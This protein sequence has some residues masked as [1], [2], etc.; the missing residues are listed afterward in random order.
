MPLIPFYQPP[1]PDDDDFDDEEPEDD[2]EEG[3]VNLPVG[4]YV[5]GDVAF[6]VN[7]EGFTFGDIDQIRRAHLTSRHLAAAGVQL[8]PPHRLAI[9]PVNRS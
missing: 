3:L 7:H 1:N 9:K 8:P 6:Y 5:P 4:V 2:P